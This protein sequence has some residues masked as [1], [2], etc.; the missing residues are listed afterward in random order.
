[1]SATRIATRAITLIQAAAACWGGGEL[2]FV[3]LYQRAHDC[4][5]I[6]S[7]SHED[8]VILICCISSHCSGKDRKNLL[9]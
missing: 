8:I 6:S 9:L 3:G 5:E 4:T 7:T 2:N 1:M